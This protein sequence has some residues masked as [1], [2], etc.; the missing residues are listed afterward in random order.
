MSAVT[1]VRDVRS[2]VGEVGGGTSHAHGSEIHRFVLEH[3]PQRC[4]EL[5][6]AWG[7]GALYI[8]SALEANGG[9]R[10]T[11]VD[12]PYEA[13]RAEVGIDLVGR[14]GLSER[15]EVVL[16][17]GGYNWF[18]HRKLKEQLRDGVLEPVYDFVFLDGAHTWLEDGLALL[19]L[20]RLVKPGGWIHLD[21]LAWLP[22]ARTDFPEAQRQFSHVRDIWELLV[23]PNDAF[24]QMRTDGVTAWA[25]RAPSDQAGERVVYQQDLSGSVRLAV[26]RARA[27][28]SDLLQ[29]RPSRVAR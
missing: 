2:L 25:R 1:T 19:L 29:R 13:R 12:M 15:V 17:E 6:F 10:L 27:R 9:G 28:A 18:L 11:S 21:D 4:L 14:A 24:D 22:T 16:E 3:K 5:G 20:E 23:V 26:D 8:A 7:V